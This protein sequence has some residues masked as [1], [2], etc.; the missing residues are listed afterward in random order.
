MESRWKI[1]ENPIA[2]VCVVFDGLCILG[3]LFKQRALI[4]ALM[5]MKDL[6]PHL[7]CFFS[8]TRHN[9]AAMILLHES[10]IG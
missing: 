10:Q 2:M 8:I 5:T 9:I 7:D 3:R 6:L 4:L 1:N